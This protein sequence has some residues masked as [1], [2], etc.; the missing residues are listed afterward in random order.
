M[1][2]DIKPFKTVDEQIEILMQ[3]GLIVD[4]IH[5]AKQLLLNLNYYRISAYSL[6]LRKN[7]NFYN[8]VHF[9]DIMQIYNFD[10]EL[11]A[12][13]L[14]LLE[15]IEVSIRTHIGYYHAKTYGPLGYLD[16]STFKDV[17][18]YEKFKLDYEN[19]IEEYGCK[20]AFVKHHKEV[21]DGR[22]PIWALVELLSFG[23]LSRVF[24][25]L[26][27]EIQDEICKNNYGRIGEVYIEN[28]LQGLTIL[29]NI[30]A[31]RGR[32]Y[33][34]E[35]PFSLRLQKRDKTALEKKDLRINK[36]TKQ[37]FVYLFV[38]NKITNPQVWQ[39]FTDRF[40]TLTAKYP[41]VSLSNYGFPD[42]W[43]SILHIRE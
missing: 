5:E 38:A 13:L 16:C 30:C 11:R 37:L 39:T 12:S 21:Y 32:I 28:W 7:D 36:A 31:H 22:F 17:N 24:K 35:I 2:H 4:D 33:N 40:T 20:E 34:R 18:R 23:S 19:A 43:K 10:M 29:R 6:T 1:A 14:Y 15:Y 9:C 42:D 26:K 27:E 41:F 25:N 3:R 8:N